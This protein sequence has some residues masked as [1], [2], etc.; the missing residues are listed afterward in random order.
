[1]S[2]RKGMALI[3]I[4][5]VGAFCM[6]GMATSWQFAASYVAFLGFAGCIVYGF[7][8]IGRDGRAEGK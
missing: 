6:F 5:A 3:V 2:K 1:M 8:V 4:G 7:H